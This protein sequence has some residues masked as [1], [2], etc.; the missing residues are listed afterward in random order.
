MTE[1][2][3]CIITP[4]RNEGKLLKH[5]IESV[6]TQSHRPCR[7]IIVNDGSTDDTGQV[8]DDAASRH[9]WISVVHR[10]DRGARQA[11]GGVM[12]AFNDGFKLLG[13]REEWDY[14]VKLDGDV[15]FD[16]DYFERCFAHFSDDAKLGI[17][18]GLIC[19]LV[20]GALQPESERDPLFHVRGATKIYRYECWRDIGGLMEITGWDT[21][22][23]LKANMMG[24]T[25]RTFRDLPV[26][27][28][29]VA[30]G[31][32]GT[33]ANWKKNGHANYVAGYHPL[34]MLLKCA[35][36]VCQRPFLVASLGLAVGFCAGYLRRLPQ[37]NDIQLI[38]Y[39]RREQM[40]RVFF[41][42]SLWA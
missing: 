29:R 3:Y 20:N 8:A 17:G 4:A 15:T 21:L 18:G 7:W 41:R 39:L 25:T 19:S 14:L 32:Y 27:H 5:T 9:E 23:E 6:L 34:F 31:A 35:S 2:R 16:R 24:W 26:V 1:R 10:S 38:R 12:E 11:G 28:H 30:G 33:W 37:V 42:K 36:R 13:S 40:K 22:D